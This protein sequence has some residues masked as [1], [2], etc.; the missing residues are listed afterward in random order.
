MFSCMPSDCTRPDCTRE[1]YGQQEVC[2]MHYQRKRRTGSY[3][4][5]PRPT[6]E[7]CFW[8]K[9]SKQGPLPVTDPDLGP[10]WNWTASSYDDTGYGQ[11]RHPSAPRGTSGYA[12]RAA[13]IYANGPIPPGLHVDHLCKNH[14]CVRAS[15]L[16][17]VDRRTNILRG[18]G[19]AAT[20]ARKTHCVHGHAF[21]AENTVWENG[22]RKC[23]TCRKKRGRERYQARKE[24]R[25]LVAQADQHPESSSLTPSVVLT[26]G[27]T[28]PQCQEE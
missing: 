15:H 24:Q 11:F 16:E 25:L 2:S 27:R 5:S 7:E 8:A 22:W 28:V 3:D 21:T 17:A 19:F 13:W 23:R 12:H 4:L 20:N 18:D 1:P 10:C 14:L 26:D 6:A 9:V